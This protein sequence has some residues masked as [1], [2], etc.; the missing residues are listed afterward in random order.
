MLKLNVRLSNLKDE[1][2]KPHEK[3]LEKMEPK[4]LKEAKILLHECISFVH[5]E[6]SSSR[7]RK[8]TLENRIATSVAREAK[9]KDVAQVR[10]E[11]KFESL[12]VLLEAFGV[13]IDR[14]IKEVISYIDDNILKEYLDET[15]YKEALRQLKDYLG[16]KL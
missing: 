8:K 11:E 1:I 5:S 15:Q 7:S 10:S 13:N 4:K 12:T 3:R 14:D 9:E 2:L 6:L 16:D